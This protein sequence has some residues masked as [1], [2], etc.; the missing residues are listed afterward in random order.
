MTDIVDYR[1]LGE[2]MQMIEFG[3][4]PAQII[5]AKI[6]TVVYMDDGIEML[7]GPDGMFARVKR[8]L[9][10]DGFSGADFLNACG[11]T[12]RIGF[13]AA[14]PGKI[15]ALNITEFGKAF[16]CQQQNL[17]CLT[18]EQVVRRATIPKLGPFGG[19][20]ASGLQGVFGEG[21]VFLHA[22]GEAVSKSLSPGET[23]V[24]DF[25][26]LIAFAQTVDW[27]IQGYY[28]PRRLC[29]ER[30]PVWIRLTGPGKVLIQTL[31]ASKLAAVLSAFR[32]KT[33]AS[34]EN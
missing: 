7:S 32:D 19:I 17:L 25:A 31:P 14:Y 33:N 34:K 11:N 8:L 1:I 13:A 2:E 4:A 6:G 30:C 22:G 3:L 23:M 15:I 20:N 9:Q 12:R 5:R 26:C 29:G 16:F 27:H 18:Q 24:V 10:G 28:R 21:Q